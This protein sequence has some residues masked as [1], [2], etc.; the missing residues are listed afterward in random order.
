MFFIP[1]RLFSFFF[2][3]KNKIKKVAIL[4]RFLQASFQ[5]IINCDSDIHSQTHSIDFCFCKTVCA[6]HKKINFSSF[7]IPERLFSILLFPK[8][9]NLTDNNG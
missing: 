1:E 7:C 4:V 9:K 8:I 3:S 2:V 5:I 6:R